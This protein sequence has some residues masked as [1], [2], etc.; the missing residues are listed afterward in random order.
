[1]SH[2]IIDRRKNDKGKS[3][4][5]R[6]RFFRR[7]RTQVKEPMKEL[8]VNG[9]IKDIIDGSGKKVKIPGR[10]LGKPFFG[11]SRHGGLKHIVVPGNKEYIAGDRI[12]RPRRNQQ[13]S[14]SGSGSGA[15]DG[16]SEDEF[17]FTL[18]EE[19]FM[20]M[21]FDDL[22]LP[23]LNKKNLAQT[24]EFESRR[25]GFAPEGNKLNVTRTMRKARGRRVALRSKKKKRLAELEAQYNELLKEPIL[26]EYKKRKLKTLEREIKILKER[27]KRVPF[28]DNVDELYNRWEQVPVPTTKA[29]MFALMDVS[30]SMG[31]RE[32]DLS[33][34]FFMLLYWF[35]KR[36]YKHVE[37]VFVRHTQIAKEVDEQEFFYS[38]ESGG[39]VVSSGIQ[40]IDEIIEDRYPLNEWNIYGCQA[41]DGDNW[42][43]DSDG[44]KNLLKEKILPKCQYYAYIQIDAMRGMRGHTELWKSYTN[45]KNSYSNFD[46]TSIK[47]AQDI[48]PVF[49]KLFKKRGA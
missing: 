2:V 26:S 37:V 34:R 11:H 8:I 5:N 28:I 23:N 15:G 46:M 31:E 42:P 18:T 39:T 32:K 44:C 49:H 20:D 13:G 30:G 40:K 33:K 19:E 14:G 27:I 22:E 7:I 21:F 1:M 9:S 48:F 17:E 47:E 29:V 35:L 45:L 43:G 12:Q 24:Q 6:Q 41:S 10:G 36:S 16:E 3:T 25:A 38:R 4:D